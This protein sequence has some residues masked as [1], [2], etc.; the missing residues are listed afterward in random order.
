LWFEA[1]KQQD[2]VVPP[3][4]TI[5]MTVAPELS[6]LRALSTGSPK[7]LSLTT[8]QTLEKQPRRVVKMVK[9]TNQPEKRGLAHTLS[10]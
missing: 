7:K 4:R 8:Y 3:S 9:L 6:P 2:V 1:T 10:E 5:M